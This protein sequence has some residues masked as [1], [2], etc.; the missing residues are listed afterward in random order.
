[1]LNQRIRT[2]EEGTKKVSIDREEILGPSPG[3]LQ[4]E[5]VRHMRRNQEKRLGLRGH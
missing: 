5:E 1:M 2:P 4:Q 3:E